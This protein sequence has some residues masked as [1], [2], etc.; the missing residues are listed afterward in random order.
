M[1][2]PRLLPDN[3]TL[4]RWI[5]RE[6][7][8]Q[9]EVC[10]RVEQLTGT[11]PSR[12]TVSVAASRAG[13]TTQQLR[14]KDEIPWKLRGRDLMAYPVRMLRLLGRRRAGLELN[15][16]ENLRLDKWLEHLREMDAVVAYDPDSQPAVFYVD[17]EPGDDD[18]IPIRRQRVWLNPQ[19]S[20]SN[21]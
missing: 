6:G 18:E 13:I 2:R 15:E 7:L 1:G 8:T 16:E 3:A 5:V 14:Y 4:E 9:E 17:R 11:R 21:A 12:S 10:D 20:T 19:Q